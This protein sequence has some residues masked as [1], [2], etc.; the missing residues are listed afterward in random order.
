MES[1]GPGLPVL[2]GYS[3][4]NNIEGASLEEVTWLI[5]SSRPS[6]CS[7]CIIY[8]A[9]WIPDGP[10][11][12]DHRSAESRPK[13]IEIGTTE[14]WWLRTPDFQRVCV[15]NSNPQD[16]HTTPSETR[17]SYA[18]GSARLTSMVTLLSSAMS[19]ITRNL[20]KP[21]LQI[22]RYIFL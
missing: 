10:I 16:Y 11:G 19:N 20:V 21:L 14:Y 4:S 3:N 7:S 9:S 5:V 2:M 17:T 12:L 1:A 6:I 22:R 8:I 13:R 18:S 15:S